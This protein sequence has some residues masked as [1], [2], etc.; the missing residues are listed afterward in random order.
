MTQ[1]RVLHVL[2]VA[3]AFVVVALLPSSAAAHPEACS[4][5]NVLTDAPTAEWFAAWTEQSEGCMN[6]A[7]VR[8]FDD[9]DAQLTAAGASDGTP[10][11]TLT[12][13]TPKAPPFETTAGPNLL[14]MGDCSP[15]ERPLPRWAHVAII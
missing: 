4:S 5:T 10:N 8:G 15:V 12:S 3:G 9:S 2:S 14:S 11:L 1:R 13:N 7:A 6:A